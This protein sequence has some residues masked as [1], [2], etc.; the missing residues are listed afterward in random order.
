MNHPELAVEDRATVEDIAAAYRLFLGRR[1][2]PGG[3]D[4]F[5][6][7]VRGGISLSRLARIFADSA[8]FRSK[9]PPET[10]LVEVDLGGYRVCI[11]PE[12]PD[13]GRDVATTADYEPHVRRAVA[14]RFREGQTFVDVGANVGCIS[15][16][17]ARIAG[18][19]GSV[20][21]VEPYPEN[22]QRLYAGISLNGLSNV[23]V[24]PL[25]ASDRRTTFSLTGGSSNAYLV[26]SQD[27]AS[28]AVYAQSVVLDEV[29]AGEPAIHMIKMDI[30]GHEPF[31]LRGLA[32]TIAAHD[33]ILL[34][35]FNPRCLS[36]TG[37]EPIDYLRQLLAHYRRLEV[38][39]PFHE[40]ATFLD[41]ES[42][43]R[44]WHERDAELSTRG[45]LAP[46]LHH[47]DVIATNE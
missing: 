31:A 41:A 23:R 13:L 3:L 7:A 4:Y 18:A 34:T 42:L 45:I 47:F 10:R 19:A 17:A 15:F 46:G 8:E 29:L 14:E 26:D 39:T 5:T 12:E 43:M 25:A 36:R 20:I 1:P 44:C 33:P 24:V 9:A 2:D 16:L 35:E 32:R 40:P 30:E 28:N 27:Y 11:D 6:R 38:I 21:A 22:L 37:H